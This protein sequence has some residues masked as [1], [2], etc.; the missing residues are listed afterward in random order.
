MI[1]VAKFGGSSLADSNQFKKV[2]DIVLKDNTIKAIIVSAPGKRFSTDNKITDLL[3]LLYAHVKYSVE[4]KELFTS[5]ENRYKEIKENLNLNLDFE[6]EFIIIKENI[7]KGMN[8]D[9]LVSRGE[10]LNAKIF[11]E[12][13]GYN[14]IDAKDIISFNF[15]GKI[16]M[17]KTINLVKKALEKNSKLVIPGFYG[18]LPNGDIKIFSRGGSDTTGSLIASIANVSVYENWTDVS[19]ILMADPRIVPNPKRINFITYS[20][21]RELSYMGANVLHTDAVDPAKKANIPINI[22]NTNDPQNP[23]TMIVNGENKIL[24]NYKTY[25]VTGI[26]GKK[27]FSV[28]SIYKYPMSEEPNSL[29]EILEVLKKYKINIEHISSGIDNFSLV[30]SNKNLKKCLY[31]ITSDIKKLDE[32]IEVKVVNDISLIAIVGRNMVHKPGTSGKLFSAMGN[33]NINIR[34]ISQS[35][36]E[37]NIIIG[38]ENKDFENCINILYNNFII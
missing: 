4:F 23:G 31:E 34:I 6:K 24:E 16:N 7:K 37:L 8:K 21:L 32:T 18:A 13:L 11:A 19:G 30:I 14:F 28:V 22:K 10:Y 2:K 25:P 5:I 36:D 15:N 1:K 38:V 12:Y 29:L 27:G 3:Y 26:A 33:A 9:Y 17:E 20:E 35:V